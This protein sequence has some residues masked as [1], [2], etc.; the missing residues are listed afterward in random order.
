MWHGGKRNEHKSHSSMIFKKK[1]VSS[2]TLKKFSP[3]KFFA[4]NYGCNLVDPNY[5]LRVNTD[6]DIYANECIF[7]KVA[8]KTIFMGL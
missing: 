4:F 5:L 1:S 3:K 6:N 7:F 8:V 2:V